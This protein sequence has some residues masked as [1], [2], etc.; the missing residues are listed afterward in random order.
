MKHLLLIL[1][2]LINSLLLTAQ[3][4]QS[5]DDYLGYKIGTRF[6]RHHKIVE[7]FNAV[8][9]AKPDMVKIEKYG[10]TNKGRDLIIAYI[11]LPENLAKLDAVRLTEKLKGGEVIEDARGRFAMNRP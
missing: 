5:P 4:L 7:Y 10:A 3:N 1:V 6:T 2:V 11:A 8:A 9:L